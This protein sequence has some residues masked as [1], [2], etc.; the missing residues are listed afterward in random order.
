M[1]ERMNLLE[2]FCHVMIFKNC[3]I[4]VEDGQRWAWLDVEVVGGARVVIIMN[5]S[6]EEERKYLQIWQPV[7]NASLW[8]KPVSCLQYVTGMEVIVVGISVFG[9]ADL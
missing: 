2:E 1:L 5:D 3:P 8:D 6:G 7:F 9:I 4:I